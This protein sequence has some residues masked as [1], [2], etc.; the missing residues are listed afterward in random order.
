M[1]S[2]DYGGD[3]PYAVLLVRPVVLLCL[4]VEVLSE[5]VEGGAEGAGDWEDVFGCGV[6][7]PDPFREIPAAWGTV[8]RGACAWT[9]A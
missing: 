8:F 2:R 5:G 1:P 6:G 3:M 7:L 9:V 4:C